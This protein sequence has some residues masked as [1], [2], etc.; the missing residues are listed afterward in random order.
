MPRHRPEIEWDWVRA[1]EAYE[2]AAPV[3]SG[4][5]LSFWQGLA[6]GL[7]FHL[8]LVRTR[9][10]GAGLPAKVLLSPETW[11]TVKRCRK[12]QHCRGLCMRHYSQAWRRKKAPGC[13]K[14]PRH[15]W[16]IRAGIIYCLYCKEPK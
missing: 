15:R 3:P 7:G 4:Q 6:D 14:A 11:C 1:K 8:A 16:V 9:F 13:P 5:S 10:R 12:V 2:K